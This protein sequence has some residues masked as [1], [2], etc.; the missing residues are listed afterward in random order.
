MYLTPRDATP[1][2]NLLGRQG[3]IMP[4]PKPAVDTAY[5]SGHLGYRFH[6]GGHTPNPDWP[7][8]VELAARF[9]NDMTPPALTPP[10]NVRLEA[11]SPA[12]AV[13]TFSAIAP[14]NVDDNVAATFS[15]ASG[16]TFAL[17]HTTVTAT[18]T[19]ISGNSSSATFKVTVRDTTP[20]VIQ[21]LT[22][23]PASLWPPNH[24]LV[25]VTLVAQVSDIADPAPQSRIVGVQV[26][27]RGRRDQ[28]GNDHGHGGDDRSPDWQT[29]APMKVRLRAEKADH[30]DRIYRI[31]VVSRD[32]SG[33]TA[34][35]TV[36]IPV[37][38]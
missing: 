37:G 2:W 35:R 1:V 6:T 25:L 17:G 7:S 4:D 33:N 16:S 21:S 11:T 27:D 34:H 9:F 22:A 15:P 31:V 30:G 36:D 38:K 8:F 3:L 19:D 12:G 32:A 20:P 5:I 18:A 24:K 26:L 28:R 14:D 29:V 10:A 23:S 13:A